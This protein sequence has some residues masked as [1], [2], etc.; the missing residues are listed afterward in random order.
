MDWIERVNE[1]IGYIEENLTGEIAY[2]KLGQIAC[3]SAYHSQR[4]F[5]YIDGMPLFED[6]RKRKISLA[7]V[8]LPGSAAKNIDVAAN[9]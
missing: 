6:I 3:C 2:E 4:L 8:D 5:A 1:A 7:T 9:Y